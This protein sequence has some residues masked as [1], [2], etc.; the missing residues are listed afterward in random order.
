MR[1]T[2]SILLSA[3]ILGAMILYPQPVDAKGV[4]E[5]YTLNLGKEQLEFADER[6]AL[7]T[8][9]CSIRYSGKRAGRIL[10]FRV[11]REVAPN[12][13][14]QP[15]SVARLKITGYNSAGERIFFQ[16]V[17]GFR[18]ESEQSGEWLYETQ[19]LPKQVKRVT[20]SFLGYIR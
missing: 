18:F 14:A 13:A 16:G 3:L 8:A 15:L 19:S 9:K 10:S 5:T 12:E 7:D 6:F 11:W 17:Q 1:R 2:I 4:L 20:I